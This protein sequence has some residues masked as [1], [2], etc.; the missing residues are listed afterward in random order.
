MFNPFSRKLETKAAVSGSGITT[1][2]TTTMPD[3]VK[4]IQNPVQL[5]QYNRGYV[6]ACTQKI[7]QVLGALPFRLYAEADAATAKAMLTSHGD[8]LTKAAKALP[9]SKKRS[10]VEIYEHPF[11]ELMQQPC[12]GM[13]RSEFFAVIS[14]YLSLLGN[15]Y[16]RIVRAGKGI[17]ALQ[18]L[19]SEYM[20][21][22]SDS[23]GDIVK[24]QYMPQGGQKQQD[25]TAAE[26]LHFRNRVPGSLIQGMGDLEAA[27]AQANLSWAAMSYVSSLLQN[28]AVPGTIVSVKG[29]NGTPEQAQKLTDK[30]LEKFGKTNRGK[31][32]IMFGETDIKRA[33]ATMQETRTEMFTLQARNEI[34]AVFG[35]PVDLLV[36]DSSNRA[37][38]IVAMQQF[39]EF[40]VCP[41]ASLILDQLNS[42]LV[43]PE[44]DTQL[45][46]WYDPVEALQG[47]PQAQT[48]TVIK[49]FQAGL[50]SQEEARKAL[51]ID[52]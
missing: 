37:T 48:E 5:M 2:L 43:K 4:L 41:R 36:T 1:S 49:Q 51:G 47:D 46:Y 38:A 32:A 21:I 44:Y 28:M 13:S 19:M 26:I 25:F 15:A 45:L 16:V 52:A 20:T 17:V 24:Y 29:F 9:K 18:P 14:G 6:Y 34:A 35:V 12:P 33:D 8:I 39:R 10:Y 42:Q 50:L 3:R 23:N 30:F 11:L 27:L 40:T 22:Y 7:A 31:P